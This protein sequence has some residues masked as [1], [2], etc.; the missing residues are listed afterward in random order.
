MS[1]VITNKIVLD[2][3]TQA[4]KGEP[5]IVPF[6]FEDEL[7]QRLLWAYAGKQ[8]GVRGMFRP[9]REFIEYHNDVVFQR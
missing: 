9:R 2:L 5:E 6:P 8:I 1:T 3:R 4:W 7:G